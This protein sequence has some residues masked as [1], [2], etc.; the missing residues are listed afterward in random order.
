VNR[1]AELE[2]P[3]RVACSDLKLSK[4]L[5]GAVIIL[6]EWAGSATNTPRVITINWHHEGANQQ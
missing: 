2:R 1:E 5:V 3:S 6:G 4:A